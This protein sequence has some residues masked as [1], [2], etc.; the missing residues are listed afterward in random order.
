M[1]YTVYFHEQTKRFAHSGFQPPTAP[2]IFGFGSASNYGSHLVNFGF[3]NRM[4]T[5]LQG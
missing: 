4:R 1:L 2:N 5:Y 3:R